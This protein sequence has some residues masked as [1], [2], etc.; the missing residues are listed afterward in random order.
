MKVWE[1]AATTV[2]PQ[3]GSRDGLLPPLLLLLTVVSGLVDAASYLKLGHVFVANMTGNVVLLGFAV[4][5][6][7]GLSVTASLAAVA[8]FLVGGVVAGRLVARL[9]AERE[10]L[11]RD[12]TALQLV[13]VAA[14]VVLAAV[15]GDPVEGVRL[16]AVIVL[17]GVAMGLQNGTARGLAVP[18]LNTTV[19]TQTL[20]GIAADSWLGR[21][22]SIG[23]RL[24][25]V[26]AM[27][28]GALIGGLLAL[29]VGT[30]APLAVA[31]LLIAMTCGGAQM[32]QIRQRQ[33]QR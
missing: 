32:A 30:A 18:D 26:A 19:L 6:A 33:V 21:G 9:G 16:Y 10:R 25:S 22:P 23:R 8:L 24:L 27:L 1:G 2:W 17:L 12:S 13:L 31:A 3:P 7:V 15:S 29:R 5:G 4:A 28:L 14:A 20:T 11:L